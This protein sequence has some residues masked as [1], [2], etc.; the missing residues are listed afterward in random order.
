[1]DLKQEMKNGAKYLS[2][3]L[4]LGIT[5]ISYAQDSV[6]VLQLDD[7]IRIGLN[8]SAQ[9]L[10]SEN[11]VQITGASL[12][13]A[14]GQFLPDLNFNSN[15]GY[16]GGNN[17]FTS[18]VPTLVDARETQLTYQ[19]SS[20]INLFNGFS[21]YSALKAAILSKSASQF[22]LERAKQQ[23]AFDITQTFLQVILDRR[24]VGYAQKNLDVSTQREAQLQELTNVGRKSISDL[25]QQQAETSNDKLFQIQSEDK[26]KNDI[27]LLLRKLKISQTDK[28]R[29]GDIVVDTAP[30]GSGYQNVQILVDTAMEQ[31]ADLKSSALNIKMAD[32]EIEGYKSGYLPKLYLQGGLVS[33]GGYFNRLYVNGADELG[34]QE[35]YGKALFGQVYGEVALSL[36]WH[37][38]DHLYNKTNV[39]IATIS[40]QN[41]QILHDD[42]MVQISSDIKQAYNDYL[43]ALQQ[44]ATANSGLISAG[45]AFEVIQGEYNVGRS[46]FISLSNAQVVLLQAQ[47]NK[48]QS[49][50][51]LALQKKIIDFYIGK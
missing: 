49:E 38:F 11:A 8:Q 48:A 1:M 36:S 15:Y 32:W 31:R 50:V 37:I 21:D 46:D 4:L 26:L 51:N 41:N 42:L 3:V 14:Y 34:P 30:L 43:A 33:N 20:T 35:P 25:Y 19:L 22:N 45:E 10:Q 23:I 9:I 7:C 28:Y 39:E 44:I 2:I 24:I 6:K 12:M 18:E 17:L 27:I 5:E 13:G 29:I 40:E 16:L 47:V